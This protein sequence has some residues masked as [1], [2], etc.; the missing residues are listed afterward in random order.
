MNSM[1]TQL[2]A[3]ITMN[4]AIARAVVTVITVNPEMARIVA[5]VVTYAS[6]V[7]YVYCK[8]PFLM[9]L[10]IQQIKCYYHCETVSTW[11]AF[12]SILNSSYFEL[13]SRQYTTVK[14]GP[15]VTMHAFNPHTWETEAGGSLEI[16]G[17]PSLH[18]ELQASQGYIKR[19]CLKFLKWQ[20]HW[21]L[22]GQRE[23]TGSSVAPSKILI[24]S[25]NVAVWC[26]YGHTCGGQRTTFKNSRMELRLHF[27]PW[28]HLTSPRKVTFKTKTK[29]GTIRE[30]FEMLIIFLLLA[31]WNWFLKPCLN[32]SWF[33]N[34]FKI[35]LAKGSLN[36][37]K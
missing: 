3:V 33:K 27:Y 22:G 5:T 10:V 7:L 32:S 1:I 28:N 12:G 4:T 20:R 34:K 17:Q 36:Y 30:W 19:P 23:S 8:C 29:S 14:A 35:L 24:Y 13:L 2:P 18:S 26:I 9:T 6:A 25:I 15:G 11:Q 21:G 16:Q 31:F 37:K